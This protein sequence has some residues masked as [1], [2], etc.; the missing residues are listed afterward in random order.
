MHLHF[1]ARIALTGVLFFACPTSSQEYLDAG[2]K[3]VIHEHA[4]AKRT[5]AQGLGAL[6][7]D[8][9]CTVSRLDLYHAFPASLKS[10]NGCKR[11]PQTIL[12]TFFTWSPRTHIRQIAMFLGTM[13]LPSGGETEALGQQAMSCCREVLCSK[14]VSPQD[15]AWISSGDDSWKNDLSSDLDRVEVRRCKCGCHKNF[16]C[17]IIIA[18]LWA[19]CKFSLSVRYPPPAIH[20]GISLLK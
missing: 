4:T 12:G 1:L 20:D 15:C 9:C 18:V 14:F 13:E 8:K 16:T 2:R 11:V 17:T 7:S 19:S 6:S 5:G 10:R 3:A